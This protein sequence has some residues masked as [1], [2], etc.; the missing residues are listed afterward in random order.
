MAGLRA[1]ARIVVALTVAVAALSGAH[2]LASSP[3]AEA[4]LT[5]APG[6]GHGVLGSASPDDSSSLEYSPGLGDACPGKPRTVAVNPLRYGAVYRGPGVVGLP[7]GVCIGEFPAS[8]MQ[9]RITAPDGTVITLRDQVIEPNATGVSI[10]LLVLPTPPGTRYQ[11][12]DGAGARSAGRL[13]GS[14][15]GRYTVRAEGGGATTTEQFVLVPAPTPRL[16]NLTGMQA[17][18]EQ[19]GRLRFGAAGQKALSTFRVG[20]FGPYVPGS[21]GLPLRTVVVGR[22]DRHG[23]AIVTLDV[24]P[25]SIAGDGYVAMLEPATPLAQPD[26]LDPRVAMF[27]V[28]RQSR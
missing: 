11:L 6:T 7:V 2:A 28:T 8:A 3:D 10:Q 19:G 5:P 13:A 21:S 16:L 20:I 24:L 25:T 4:A 23:Q 27:D 9:V 22:A 17:S 18:V 1:G 15:A 12:V 26:A 14:G